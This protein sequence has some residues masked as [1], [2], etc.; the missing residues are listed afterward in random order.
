LSVSTSA[1][2]SPE[3]LVSKMI[4]YVSSET[5]THSHSSIIAISA[6]VYE[7]VADIVHATI[8]T[9]VIRTV[10]LIGRLL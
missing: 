6:T 2:D 5:V 10:A 7:T 8:V 9:T 3:R 4:Y 1:I